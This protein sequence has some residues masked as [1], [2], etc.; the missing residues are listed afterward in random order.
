MKKYKKEVR[1]LL[2]KSGAREEDLNIEIERVF[3]FANILFEKWLA[4]QKKI[5]DRRKI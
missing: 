2:R 4:H 1:N 5:Y 3:D